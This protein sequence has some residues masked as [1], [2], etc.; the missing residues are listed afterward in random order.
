MPE[1]AENF[2][3]PRACATRVMPEGL[4]GE[5]DVHVRVTPEGVLGAPE[6]SCMICHVTLL[7]TWLSV[8][9]TACPHAPASRSS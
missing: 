4:L 3:R 5:G 7:L 1:G 9:T 8:P 6:G 2:R